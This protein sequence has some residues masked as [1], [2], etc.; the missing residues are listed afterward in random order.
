MFTIGVGWTSGRKI[1]FFVLLKFD[2][3]KKI[4]AEKGM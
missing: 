1:S 2:R 4:A 3:K